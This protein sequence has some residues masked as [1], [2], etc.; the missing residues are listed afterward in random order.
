MISSN[1]R[2]GALRRGHVAAVRA[3]HEG[4]AVR[5]REALAEDCEVE[6]VADIDLEV[7]V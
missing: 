3:R 1:L 5:S 2:G 7:S 4:D 6:A